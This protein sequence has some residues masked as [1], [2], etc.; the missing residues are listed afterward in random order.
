MDEHKFHPHHL[1]YLDS[2]ERRALL[3]LE[4]ILAALPLA[5]EQ[6]VADLGA[7]SGFF[8]SALAR[9]LPQGRIVAIDVQPEM[10][11]AL[12]ARV[13][14]EGLSNVEVMAS[15]EDS[16]PLSAK[17]VDGALLAF[18]LHETADPSALLSDVARIVKPGGWLAILEFHKR[19]TGNGPPVHIR[20][21][22]DD[23]YPSLDVAGFSGEEDLLE[24][25]E[26]HYLL[27]ARR[28]AIG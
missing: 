4:R 28:K 8:T 27:L 18:V 13:T 9:A 14:R 6:T 10:I 19:D 20:L 12:Q 26:H 16:I 7:G 21:S 5:P 17:T 22:P 25:N 11:A 24:L 15:V 3:D 1:E 2:A 23:L